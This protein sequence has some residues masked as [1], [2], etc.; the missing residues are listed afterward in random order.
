MRKRD[1]IQ[2]GVYKRNDLVLRWASE[3]LSSP[4][5]RR[6]VDVTNRGREILSDMV[7]KRFRELA[8]Q[9]MADI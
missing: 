4:P 5:T 8:A 7:A 1:T 2:H 6:D 3:R 9:D